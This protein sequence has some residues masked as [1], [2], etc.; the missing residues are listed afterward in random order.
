MNF[1]AMDTFDG[2]DL[3]FDPSEFKANRQAR[4]PKE[5]KR[6]FRKLPEERR[7]QEIYYAQIALRN[8][9]CFAE[10]PD[11]MQKKI[12]EVGMYQKFE[13]RRVLLR[14]GHPA[15]NYYFIL[16]GA[17]S[18]L[19]VEE[20]GSFAR[21]ATHLEKGQ[22]FGELAII[23]RG[24][25]HSSI[26]VKEK[27][28][29]LTISVDDYHKIFM[30]GGVKSV[31]DPDH[32]R[33]IKSLPFLQGWPVQRLGD[34]DSKC[35]FLYFKR[36]DV[37]V[38]DSQYSDW[39][40]VVK[41]GSLTVLKK[42]RKVEAYEWKKP[43]VFTFMSDK[44]K[45]A[46]HLQ[47]TKMKKQILSEL[48]IPLR[49]ST[50]D[51]HT[52]DLQI[53]EEGKLRPFVHPDPYPFLLLPAEGGSSED[54]KVWDLGGGG[55]TGGGTTGKGDSD[56]EAMSYLHVPTDDP[57]PD[58]KVTAPAQE[59][60]S[61]PSAETAEGEEEREREKNGDEVLPSGTIAEEDEIDERRSSSRSVRSSPKSPGAERL[62]KGNSASSF[63]PHVRTI[64]QDLEIKRDP[65]DIS[66][67]D[68]NPEFVQVQT[69]T[70]GMC[71]GLSD[72]ILGEG[73]NFCVVS[74]GADVLLVN[75]TFYHDHA[76]EDLIRRMRQA[77]CPYPSEEELQNRLQTSVDWDAYR[78]STLAKTLKF[79]RLRKDT[80]V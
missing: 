31:N 2:V 75:K 10:F 32:E 20:G 14:Q 8:I 6:I 12:A 58:V 27:S 16:S 40:I 67:A 29:F 79:V 76:S 49:E 46:R 26:V 60:T 39:I 56:L 71:F 38:R 5:M 19:V 74:N 43:K 44:E 36:G 21:L 53:R 4:I 25:R 13:P 54:V 50:D 77:L 69:L 22:T 68:L 64:Q 42:L 52:E 28:E 59:D 70:K 3:L 73:S 78:Q 24:T 48:Q 80:P 45:R 66:A 41:S 35:V 65:D 18:V 33:F 62:K 55:G 9:K 17:V 1:T 47:L 63:Q 11:R 30:C 72:L 61:V 51:T 23:K 57:T 34:E 15:H 37:I 7:E